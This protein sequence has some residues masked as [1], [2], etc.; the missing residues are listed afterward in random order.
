MSKSIPAIYF[1]EAT[2]STA[3][4]DNFSI[5]GGVDYMFGPDWLTYEVGVSFAF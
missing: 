1:A 3:A 2:A 4:G 5:Y